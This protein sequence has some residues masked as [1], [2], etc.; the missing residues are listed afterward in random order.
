MYLFLGRESMNSDHQKNS[1]QKVKKTF[2]S[3]KLHFIF[4][5]ACI[6][7]QLVLC[8]SCFLKNIMV[9]KFSFF[10]HF[11]NFFILLRLTIQKSTRWHTFYYLISELSAILSEFYHLNHGSEEMQYFVPLNVQV[12]FIDYD[13]YTQHLSTAVLQLWVK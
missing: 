12:S 3:V 4:E 11:T 9:L 13:P 6:S 7:K 8:V 2:T 1:T 10:P 5:V